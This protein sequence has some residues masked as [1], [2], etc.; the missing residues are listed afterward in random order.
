MLSDRLPEKFVSDSCRWVLEV[1]RRSPCLHQRPFDGL[2]EIV[3]LV[4]GNHLRDAIGAAN[5]EDLMPALC[6]SRVQ[7]LKSTAHKLIGVFVLPFVI[8]LPGSPLVRFEHRQILTIHQAVN[9]G[10]DAR[11]FVW[12]AEQHKNAIAHEGESLAVLLT[13][14]ASFQ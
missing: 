5:L 6:F 11:C 13:A 4:S 7:C 9:S 2:A 12:K 10:D 14:R 1:I 3:A 8:H